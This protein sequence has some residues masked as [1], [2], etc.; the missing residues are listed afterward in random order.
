M[1]PTDEELMEHIFGVS[2]DRITDP[3]EQYE[4]AEQDQLAETEREICTPENF[5]RL[6][7]RVTK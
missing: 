7:G 6:Y 1:I 2:R 5:E 4:L 3:L